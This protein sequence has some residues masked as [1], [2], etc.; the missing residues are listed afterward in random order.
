MITHIPC[1]IL[2]GGKSSRMGEDKSLLPFGGFDTLLEY[3]YNKLSKI[4][5]NVYISSKKEKIDTLNKEYLYIVDNDDELYSPILA[6]QSIFNT[7]KE[8]KVF[9]IT[10][11]VPF[12]SETTIK[13]L[14]S[15]SKDYEITIARDEEIVHNLC[16]VFSNDL[17]DTIDSM[18]RD[19]I[20]RVN[21]M[22]RKSPL[23]TQIEFK[24]KNEFLNLNDK[25]TYKV[26]KSISKSYIKY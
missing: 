23:S 24:D 10:V 5:S 20:H 21:Y 7:L 19:D 13:E 8:K 16:G 15:K 2:C 14:V 6:L 17:L 12:V 3:Q 22:I 26:A 11:D 4:F 9:L 18:L 25:E 1:V